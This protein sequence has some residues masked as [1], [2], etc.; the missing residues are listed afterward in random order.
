MPVDVGL[1]NP[2]IECAVL[3]ITGITTSIGDLGSL[4]AP[5][6]GPCIYGRDRYTLRNCHL[7]VRRHAIIASSWVHRESYSV[8]G[9]RLAGS[10]LKSWGI[11]GAISYYEEGMVDGMRFIVDLSVTSAVVHTMISTGSKVL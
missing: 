9:V 1:V 8:G 2:A 5:V 7:D 10:F 11:S 4:F 6:M 3:S